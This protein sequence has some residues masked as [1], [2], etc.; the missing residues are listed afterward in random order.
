MIIPL[1]GDTLPALL[2]QILRYGVT[3]ENGIVHVQI[4]NTSGLIFRGCDNFHRECVAAFDGVSD[5]LLDELILNGVL[6]GKLPGK[7]NA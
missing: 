2:K 3:D 7:P 6:R 1:N 4:A 5:S